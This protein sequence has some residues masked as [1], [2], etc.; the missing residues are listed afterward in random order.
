MICVQLF[1]Q[2]TNQFK[3]QCGMHIE[4]IQ[5]LLASGIVR[6]VHVSPF[7]MNCLHFVWLCAPER[8]EDSEVQLQ[9]KGFALH[10]QELRQIT[11]DTLITD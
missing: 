8:L 7:H 3:R 10:S 11:L 4:A 6:L 5:A 2:H 9:F 1:D